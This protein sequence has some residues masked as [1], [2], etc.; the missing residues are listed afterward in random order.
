MITIE[1]T[2]LDGVK[3][4]RQKYFED[5]RGFYRE[6]FHKDEYNKLLNFDLKEHDISFSTKNVLRGIHGD[7]K[8]DKIISCLSGRFHL[9]VV[10][11]D[12]SSRQ[13][14]QWESFILTENNG[15]QVYV[16]KGFGNGHL[17]LS[18]NCIFHY[19]QSENYDIKSQFTIRYNDKKFNFWWPIKNIILSQRDETGDKKYVAE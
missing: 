19:S 1:N 2:K 13:Y 11:N 12:K 15:I 18:K 9:V 5:F 4:I 14:R 3:L 8:T 6:L 16:P 7:N 17:C 10:N